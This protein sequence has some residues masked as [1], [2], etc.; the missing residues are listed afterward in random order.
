MKK[1]KLLP[2]GTQII[3]F[4]DLLAVVLF[5]LLC[6]IY[7]RGGKNILNITIATGSL[8]ASTVAIAISYAAYKNSDNKKNEELLQELISVVKDIKANQCISSKEKGSRTHRNIKRKSRHNR[9]K[10]V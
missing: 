9:N 2:L 5:I 10:T 7:I 1:I 6:L 3:M 4:I 8:M